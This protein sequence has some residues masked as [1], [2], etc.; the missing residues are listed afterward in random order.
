[1]YI[2]KAGVFKVLTGLFL[3]VLFLTASLMPTETA[4]AN[5]EGYKSNCITQTDKDGN[6]TSKDANATSNPGG[7]SGSWTVKG[8]S[9]YNTAKAVWD[10][11][12]KVGMSGAQVAGIIGNIG[13]AE[14]TGFVLDQKEYGGGSGGG[15]YQFTPY[16]KYLND[17]KSDQSWSADNQRDVVMHLEPQT[18]QNYVSQTKSSTPEDCA[19]KW[20]TLY[21]RPADPAATAAARSAAARKAYELFG[22]ANISGNSALSGSTDAANNGGEKAAQ[23]NPCGGQSSATGD[24]DGNIV[25]VAKSLIGYFHYAQ[26]HGTS[27]IGSVENPDKNGQT[28]CS[29]FVWLALTKAGYKTP[30]NMQ[31]F[32]MPMEQDAKSGHKWFKEVSSSE[33]GPGDVVIVNTGGGEGSAGH[34][35]ILEEKWK[36]DNT[37]IIQMGGISGSA[38]VNESTF[39]ASFL[40]LLSSGKPV[41][42]RPIKK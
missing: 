37:K 1:M 12:V 41:F 7:V 2:K 10:G 5:F 4:L 40:S 38:G 20:E 30:E 33:A 14:D 24:S 11:W 29:G 34:T 17:E 6:S 28:D 8:T 25:N 13:G 42:A 3:S 9:A 15:L 31:W 32:T 39:K 23:N 35:A 22:G 27:L 19:V 21:E 26:V 18:V 36:G 16:S